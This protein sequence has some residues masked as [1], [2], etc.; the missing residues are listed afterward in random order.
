MLPPNDLLDGHPP[1]PPAMANRFLF[2]RCESRSREIEPQ[3][4]RR[5][6]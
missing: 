4:L 1:S 5:C 6:R 2:A 3:V